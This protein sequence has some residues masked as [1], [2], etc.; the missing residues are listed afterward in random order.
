VAVKAQYAGGDMRRLALVSL[1]VVVAA[2]LGAP[3]AAPH[4]Q[5]TADTLYVAK[6][7][8]GPILFAGNGRTLYAF[9][10]DPRH[11][12]VCSGE[13][14]NAWPPFLVKTFPQAG[15]GAN[16]TLL[17]SITRPDGKHHVT[18]GGRPLY[19]YHGEKKPGQVLCQNVREFGG[20]WLVVRGS[21]KLVR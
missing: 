20:L 11:R 2:G 21:G 6:S 18:Y 1:T 14:A 17:G 4:V 5:A 12:S 16:R 8:Y 10:K 15:K 19:Y 9:T 7:R 3:A 13:C